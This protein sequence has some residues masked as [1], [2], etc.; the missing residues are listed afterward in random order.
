MCSPSRSAPPSGE[1]VHLG[2]QFADPVGPDLMG[3]LIGS[4]GTLAIVTSVTVRI[5]R[6][7]ESVQTL[8]AAFDTIDAAGAAVS[9]IIGAGIIPAAIEMMDALAIQAAEAAVHPG[10]PPADTVLI[11]EL[12]GPEAEVRALFGMVEDICDRAGATTIEVA[13]SEEQRARIWKG[14]K[15][16][17]AAM[18]RVSP[19]YYVQAAWCRERV[20]RKSS[21]VFAIWNAPRGCAS[22]TCSTPATATCTR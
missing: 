3:L 12:D 11:V 7:P 1:L 18:G 20:C 4:E 13:Q 2:S 10:F 6:K 5:L 9:E 17:F 16:A 22:A 14:R 8:L 19:N 21:G 15:A